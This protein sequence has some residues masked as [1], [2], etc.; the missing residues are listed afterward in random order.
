M[1][2]T[3]ATREHYHGTQATLLSRH[4]EDAGGI[5]RVP[6]SL[7]ITEVT[8]DGTD[9]QSWWVATINVFPNP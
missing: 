6:L 5:G 9:N 7:D 4:T 8:I 1:I 2:Y 3:G